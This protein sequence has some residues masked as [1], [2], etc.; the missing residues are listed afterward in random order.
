MNYFWCAWLITWNL[1]FISTWHEYLFCWDQ[2]TWNKFQNE[3]KWKKFV[4][5]F[6]HLS[7]LVEING[8]IIWF[9]GGVAIIF[10]CSCTIN[11]M[12]LVISPFIASDYWIKNVSNFKNPRFFY[13]GNFKCR[14]SQK[15]NKVKSW[16]YLILMR[17]NLAL[18]S[19]F[20][21]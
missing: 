15:L 5:F 2:M 10:P 20:L 18:Y 9:S 14:D 7:D 19:E 4:R 12:G 3:I 17:L 16:N 11:W 21:I 1:C 13:L 6:T 8:F